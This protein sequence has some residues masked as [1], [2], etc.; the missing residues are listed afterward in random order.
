[1]GTVVGWTF[2][3]QVP[4]YLQVAHDSEHESARQPH[5]VQSALRERM[6][7]VVQI[8]F[9]EV[10]GQRIGQKTWASSEFQYPHDS[11]IISIKPVTVEFY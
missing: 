6:P 2:Q 7:V 11:S 1:M 10:H 4:S 3:G 5:D 8:R 9:D